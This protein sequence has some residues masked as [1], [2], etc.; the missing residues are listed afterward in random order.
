MLEVQFEDGRSGSLDFSQ[1]IS[2]GTVFEKLK[3]PS[4]FKQFFIDPSTGALAWPG[5]IDIAPETLYHKAT[6]EP[7]PDWMEE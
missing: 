4:F 6:G 1:F 5:R 2:T 7:L 3:D